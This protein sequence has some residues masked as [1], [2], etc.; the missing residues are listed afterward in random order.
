MQLAFSLPPARSAGSAASGF[1]RPSCISHIFRTLLC[2]P[3]TQEHFVVQTLVDLVRLFSSHMK[4]AIRPSNTN[5]QR[6]RCSSVYFFLARKIGMSLHRRLEFKTNF[7][8][9]WK[10]CFQKEN[11]ARGSS[12]KFGLCY[13]LPIFAQPV[14]VR[15]RNQEKALD[16]Q[17]HK[18]K[19]LLKNMA[20]SSVCPHG[21]KNQLK[22]MNFLDKITYHVICVSMIPPFCPTVSHAHF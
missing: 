4:G 7:V 10:H 17:P 5:W 20:P 22:T 13:N 9:L 16:I 21:T 6:F 2:N 18:A 1:Y 19:T 11:A 8:L 12:A 3:S 14:F 15:Q